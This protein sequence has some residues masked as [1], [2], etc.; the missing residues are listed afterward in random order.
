MER[1]VAERNQSWLFRSHVPPTVLQYV[2][3]PAAVVVGVYD[4][5]IA[6]A[7]YAHDSSGQIWGAWLPL[8][9]IP[10]GFLAC[11]LLRPQRPRGL[12]SAS[13]AAVA[14]FYFLL[15]LVALGRAMS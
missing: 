8:L 4:V 2:A 11:W 10:L 3:M 7:F 12:A 1:S 6:E 13:M 14:V 5:V 9:L 15:G